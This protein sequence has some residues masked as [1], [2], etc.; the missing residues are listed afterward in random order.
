MHLVPTPLQKKRKKRSKTIVFAANF[1]FF[2][3]G[4]RGGAKQGALWPM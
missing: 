3:G 4:G 1:I 2:K